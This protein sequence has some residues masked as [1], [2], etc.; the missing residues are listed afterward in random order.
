MIK[1]SYILANSRI[2]FTKIFHTE[3]GSLMWYLIPSSLSDRSMIC[4]LP[5]GRFCDADP[6]PPRKTG[7]IRTERI[8]FNIKYTSTLADKTGTILHSCM[9]ACFPC[10]GIQVSCQDELKISFIIESRASLLPYTPPPPEDL[11]I[12]GRIDPSLTPQTSNQP[13]GGGAHL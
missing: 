11:Y 7:Y 4:F 1:I 6:S 10:A 9:P 13:K 5:W 2:K 8:H 12:P 3:A